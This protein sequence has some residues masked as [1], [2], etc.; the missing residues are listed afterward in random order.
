MKDS[1]FHNKSS[2]FSFAF[3]NGVQVHFD[4]VFINKRTYKILFTE[5]ISYG[6]SFVRRD[7]PVLHRVVD[8]CMNDEPARCCTSLTGCANS[9]KHCTTNGNIKIRVL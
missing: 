5:W 9:A 7:Q 3:F 6:K 8:V 4:G 2:A 1:T